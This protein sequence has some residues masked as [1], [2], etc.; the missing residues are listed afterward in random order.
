MTASCSRGEIRFFARL[1]RRD[2]SPSP[3]ASAALGLLMGVAG[4]AAALAILLINASGLI[5]IPLFPLE[6]LPDAARVA[7]IL[8]LAVGPYAAG[9][10]CVCYFGRWV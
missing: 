7:L 5:A 6:I 8:A 2:R 9:L 4:L 10:A 1:T 3:G